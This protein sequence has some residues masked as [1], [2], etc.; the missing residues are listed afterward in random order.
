MVLF[1]AGCGSQIGEVAP[2]K[3]PLNDYR[4]VSVEVA[5][6]PQVEQPTVQQA[7]LAMALEK[8]LRDERAFEVVPKS[9]EL[10]VRVTIDGVSAPSGS[11]EALCRAR[12]VLCVS[13]EARVQGRADI[14]DGKSGFT[15]GTIAGT[16]TSNRSHDGFKLDAVQKSPSAMAHDDFAWMI[17]GYLV[18]HRK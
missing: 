8:A 2:L 5:S 14:V 1:L 6:G 11:Q 10:V 17:S 4:T 9:G 3:A 7:Q 13:D 12:S 15:L 16:G 18:K